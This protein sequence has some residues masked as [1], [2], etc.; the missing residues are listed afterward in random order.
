MRGLIIADEDEAS[1]VRLGDLLRAEGYDVWT[2]SSVSSAVEGI[3]KNV[4]QVV[5]LGGR[6]DGVTA[7]KLIPVLKQCRG[8][9]KVI[10]VS[11]ETSLAVL[12]QLRQKGIFYYLTKPVTAEDRDE[13]RQVVQCAFGTFAVQHGPAA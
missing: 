13:V 5:I 4:V 11:E 10:V 6:I 8:D 2:T 7:A 3:L 12:R 9:V 1:R